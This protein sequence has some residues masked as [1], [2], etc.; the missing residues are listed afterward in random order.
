M[1]E[2]TFK[3]LKKMAM[4]KL[5]SN[6]APDYWTGYLRGLRQRYNGKKFS[7]LEEH[8]RWLR[9]SGRGSN[10]PRSRG[11]RDGYGCTNRNGDCMRCEYVS[12]YGLDCNSNSVGLKKRFQRFK[13][14]HFNTVF[15][16]SD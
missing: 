4:D 11:Y 10:E 6:N 15:H 12:Y 16:V 5:S 13:S 3:L 1:Y 7:S 9:G 8:H 14:N 2:E